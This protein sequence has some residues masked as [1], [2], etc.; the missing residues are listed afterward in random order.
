[1]RLAQ[2]VLL[3][4]LLTACGIETARPAARPSPTAPAPLPAP[5]AAPARLF[6]VDTLVRSTQL[7]GVDLHVRYAERD[8]SSLTLHIAFY[9]NSGGDLAFVSGVLPA[10][11]RLVGTMIMT[12]TATSP[13]LA[14]GI[15]PAAT[16]LS[17][18]ATNGTI[19][20]PPSDSPQ[21][22]LQL[23]GFPDVPL[24]F[25]LPLQAAPEPHA[26][27]DGTYPFDFELPALANP[28]QTVR[29]GTVTLQGDRLTI[30]LTPAGTA[31]VRAD[32]VAATLLDGRWN[33]V[34]ATATLTP[35]VLSFA[36]PA[37]G[38]Q[39]LLGLA[40]FPVVRL[41][42]RPNAEP[43]LATA[44]DLP[45]S[46]QPRPT[47]PAAPTT[48]P[49]SASAQA[50]RELE[51]LPGQ[52]T[53]A[54]ASRDRAAYLAA[55]APSL[56]AAQGQW[57]AALTT[58]PLRDVAF[59]LASAAPPAGASGAKLA[60]QLRY[61]VADA[62]PGNEFIHDF[63][64]SLERA[65][66]WQITALDGEAPFWAGG[67]LQAERRGAFWIFFPAALRSE[68]PQLAAETA[69]AFERVSAALPGRTQPVNV[70]VVAAT[71]GDFTRLTGR[72]GARFAG[73]ALYRYLITGAGVRLTNQAFYVNGAAFQEPASS[74]REQV[75]THEFTTSSWRRA[76]CRSRRPG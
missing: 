17:N 32:T 23:P 67:A 11:A 9:N 18:A 5:T 24:R 15:A 39:L 73:A 25:A 52:L 71:A 43:A 14:H 44:A 66:H 10:T 37:A 38:E 76:P 64:L 54:L 27:Q 55:F 41:T 45:P 21:L 6:A 51:A 46:A 26:P 65:T 31:S 69:R 28:A 40:G 16:W 22:T 13:S 63:D 42:L 47:A 35:T 75:I 58:L 36:R 8:R 34:T 12:A 3:L 19:T 2:L 48:G 29:I 57:F 49:L 4:T 30:A 60:V 59:T 68:L 61:T 20:F 72:P 70:I 7:P 62:D 50:G 53:A 1:M 33:P 74:S 56:Q